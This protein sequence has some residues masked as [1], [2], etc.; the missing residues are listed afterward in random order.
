MKHALSPREKRDAH[1]V[2]RGNPGVVLR[3]R[4]PPPARRRGRGG[5]RGGGGR[6]G[7]LGGAGRA[8]DVRVVRQT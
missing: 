8:V 2:V 3:R 1:T 5:G 7:M 4:R 6:G